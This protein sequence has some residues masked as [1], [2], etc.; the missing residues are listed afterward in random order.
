MVYTSMDDVKRQ[1]CGPVIRLALRCP[2]KRVDESV[3]VSSF[4]GVTKRLRT[5]LNQNVELRGTGAEPHPPLRGTL[6]ETNDGSVRFF[7]Y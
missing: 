3:Y 6:D 1:V 2:N 4:R 5:G 7:V